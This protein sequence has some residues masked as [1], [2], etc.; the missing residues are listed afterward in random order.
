MSKKKKSR[1][2]IKIL[3]LDGDG[4]GPEIAAASR[5]VLAAVNQRFG[6]NLELPS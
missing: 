1:N 3:C 2:A 5:N 6:L 4:I